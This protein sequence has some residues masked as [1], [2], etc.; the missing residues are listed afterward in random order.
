MRLALP[1]SVCTSKR[2]A[3]ACFATQT[4]ECEPP[5][6]VPVLP[7]CVRRRFERPFE[8]FFA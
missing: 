5:V 4:G 8:V 3:I 2:R 6:D 1:R 7:R